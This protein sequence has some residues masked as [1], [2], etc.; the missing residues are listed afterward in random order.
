MPALVRGGRSCQGSLQIALSGL[1]L[2]EI[3]QKAGRKTGK[4]YRERRPNFEVGKG[5]L[6]LI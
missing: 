2:Q 4:A 3:D 6:R 5:E 1:N